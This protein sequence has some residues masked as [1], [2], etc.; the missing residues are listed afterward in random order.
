MDQNILPAPASFDLGLAITGQTFRAP[1]PEG[2]LF[3]PVDQIDAVLKRVQQFF[4]CL[5]FEIH[6]ERI[7][8]DFE[9]LLFPSTHYREFRKKPR[10]NSD[11]VTINHPT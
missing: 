8:P 11:V 6:V 10:K 9:V 1:V 5:F 7:L 2:D 4:Q 3:V